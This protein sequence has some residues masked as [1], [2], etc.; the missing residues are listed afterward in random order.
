MAFKFIASLAVL[1]S[2]SA[3]TPAFAQDD[4][5]AALRFLGSTQ[6]DCDDRIAFD[7]P[8]GG[9]HDTVS[10]LRVTFDDDWNFE[11]IFRTS[12]S[13]G[14]AIYT[15]EYDISGSAFDSAGRQGIV[16]DTFTKTERASLPEGID[17]RNMAVA[18]YDI[19]LEGDAMGLDGAWQDTSGGYGPS[20]CG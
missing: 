12:L 15:Q 17:W 14:T 1:A 11:G 8:E 2:V 13:L 4:G 18:V 6:W 3:T 20:E 10:A 7:G 19:R 5:D 9:L 16:I